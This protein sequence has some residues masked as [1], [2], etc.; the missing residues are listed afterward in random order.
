MI[1]LKLKLKDGTFQSFEFLGRKC[2][3]IGRWK[4][5]DV[6][7]DDPT[8]SGH[9]AN[10]D[11]VNDLIYLYDLDSQNGSFVNKKR[12]TSQLLKSGDV[13]N[14]GNSTIEYVNEDL[15]SKFDE[16]ESRRSSKTEFIDTTKNIVDDT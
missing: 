12:I 15:E 10:V 4:N 6:V 2:I 16:L 1:I 3:S 13:I 7:L 14:L 9:H 5:K 11:Y 8:V